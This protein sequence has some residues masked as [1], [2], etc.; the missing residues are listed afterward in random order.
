MSQRNLLVPLNDLLV[1]IV[2][3]VVGSE[4]VGVDKATQRVSTLDEE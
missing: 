3:A 1:G 2:V 4:A